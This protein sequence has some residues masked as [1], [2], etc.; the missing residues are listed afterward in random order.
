MILTRIRL[1]PMHRLTYRLIGDVDA[2]HKTLCACVGDKRD[3]AGLLFRIEEGPVLLV[4]SQTQP[5]WSK[6]TKERNVLQGDPEDKAFEPVFVAGATYAFR[7][8]CRPS[9]KVKVDG[10]KNSSQRFLRTEEERFAWLSRQGEAHGFTVKRVEITH[11]SWSLPD[12]PSPSQRAGDL[13]QAESEEST[14]GVGSNSAR[15]TRTM[16]G[17]R[18]DGVLMV[19]DPEKLLAAVRNGIGPQKAFGF[20]LLSLAPH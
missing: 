1:N 12:G 2:L 9:K 7:L 18:F 8:R 20:G 13:E 6:F 15:A 4:Q 5:D 14:E 19:T 3:A 10:K 11:E 16:P 17:V